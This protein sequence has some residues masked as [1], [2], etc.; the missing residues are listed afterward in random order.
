MA[1]QE[2][3][4]LLKQGV[5]VWNQWRQEYPEKLL[6]LNRADLTQTNLSETALSGANLSEAIINGTIFAYIDLRETR[7][8]VKLH[9]TGPSAVAMNTIQLPQDGSTLHFLR[10]AGVSDEWIDFYRA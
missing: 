4:D 9:H 7:G 10:G 8:L 2:Q 5:E 3:L 6:D 1:N